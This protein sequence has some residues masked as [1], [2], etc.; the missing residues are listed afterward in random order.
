MPAKSKSIL[1][2]GAGIG[3]IKAACDLAELGFDVHLVESAPNTGGKLQQHDRWFPTDDCSM[4]QS[5]PSLNVEGTEERCMRRVL[6]FP[7]LIMH[8]YSELESLGGKA[9]KFKARLRNKSRLIKPELC[10]GSLSRRST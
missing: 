2:V 3:G 4:C 9:G 8:T 1:V 6:A 5:L 7:G 10:T